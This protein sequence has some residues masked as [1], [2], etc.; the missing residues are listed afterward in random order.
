VGKWK[1]S[2]KMASKSSQFS[3]KVNS[4][5]RGRSETL[6]QFTFFEKVDQLVDLKKKKSND[7]R[8][9]KKKSRDLSSKVDC[10]LQGLWGTPRTL[11]S[12]FLQKES[13]FRTTEVYFYLNV[14]SVCPCRVPLKAVPSSTGPVYGAHPTPA[15]T[16]GRAQ[17]KNN[18]SLN[19]TTHS[20]I[21]QKKKNCCVFLNIRCVRVM[22]P[23]AH[24][25][26]ISLP[27]VP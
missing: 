11:N 9:L 25:V 24:R 23:D 2:Y 10:R 6:Q 8:L 26:N 27:M 21:Y 1:N 3:V 19:V 17:T 13:R 22:Q 4:R 15:S 5:L 12:I 16:S 20:L 18:M 7:C 14:V